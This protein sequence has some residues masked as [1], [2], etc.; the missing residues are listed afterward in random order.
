MADGA[1]E[2]AQ[3]WFVG[4]VSPGKPSPFILVL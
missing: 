2:P 1:V 4:D 3:G